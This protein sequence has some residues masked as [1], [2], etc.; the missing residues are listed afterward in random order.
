MTAIEQ[1]PAGEI[2]AEHRL[3]AAL[4]HASAMVQ[5]VGVLVGVLVYITQ[6]EKS[7]YAA[8]QALQAAVFQLI[9]LGLIIAMW[10]IWTAA[11]TVGTIPLIRLAESAPSDA[12]PALFWWMM[13]SM[14]I[15]LVYM[16]VVMAIGLWAGLRTWK[17]RDFRYPL[18][19]PW[20][21]RSGLWKNDEPG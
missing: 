7:R 14:M 1:T 10:L 17:G 12:P 4:A 8:F 16:L 13:G 19:G 21:E 15:P 5:G 9:N 3:L 11:I 18:I 2:S 20:L 6:R